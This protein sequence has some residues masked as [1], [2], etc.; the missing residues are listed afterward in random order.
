MKKIENEFDLITGLMDVN[1]KT[2]VDVGCGVG[3]LVRCLTEKNA[4]VTGIDKEIM[5]E[6]AKAEEPAGNETYIEG[7]AE[8][9]PMND[10]SVDLVI[11]FASLH[12]VPAEEMKTA[13]GETYRVLKPNGKAFF[14]E[15]VGVEGSYFQ[16]IRL[17][18]DERPVQLLAKK[19]IDQAPGMGFKPIK[20]EMFYMERSL[21]DYGKILDMFVPDEEKREEYRAQAKEI[22][23]QLCKETGT[24][25]EDYLYR[26]IARVN[27]FEK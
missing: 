1:G 24:T 4:T 21:E 22:T 14:L 10:N 8:H 27:I 7:G 2:V 12:H 6:K 16:L 15:P 26:S 17:V 20:E 11:F 23:E 13:L 25:I 19:V 5:L 3:H 9:L 18:D